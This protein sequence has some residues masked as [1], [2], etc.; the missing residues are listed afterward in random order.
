MKTS[1]TIPDHA[2][3]ALHAHAGNYSAAEAL[4][5]PGGDLPRDPPS[6]DLLARL[7][8]QQ[9]DHAGAESL[10]KIILKTE[11]GHPS[12]LAGIQRIRSLRSPALVRHAGALAA[13]LLLAAILLL[14]LQQRQTGERQTRELVELRQALTRQEAALADRQTLAARQTS[15]ELQTA[16]QRLHALITRS[17]ED[18]EALK[19]QPE[20]VAALGSAVH[21]LGQ[22]LEAYAKA[23][24]KHGTTLSA[25]QD[26]QAARLASLAAT[27]DNL[28]GVLGKQHQQVAEHIA[29]L[30]AALNARLDKL[31][32]PPSEPPPVPPTSPTPEAASPPARQ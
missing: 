29:S 10:W 3:A 20:K 12:A 8:A 2:Q 25:G 31:H 4:L 32:P 26:D 13:C 27:V 1:E 28:R 19:G 6:L 18:L 7:R 21:D 9:G 14:L 15:T 11:P 22:Q 30:F 23:F 24:T 5:R 16:E 17:H